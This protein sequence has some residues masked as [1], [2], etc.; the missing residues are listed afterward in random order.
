M[1][2]ERATALHSD[3]RLFYMQDCASLMIQECCGF[4]S[5]G[6]LVVQT[7]LL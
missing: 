3:G 4:L 6:L 7:V 5:F 1:D 2:P